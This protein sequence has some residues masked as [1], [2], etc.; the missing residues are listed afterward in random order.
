MT[1]NLISFRLDK[2]TQ[3]L[4]EK[5]LRDGESLSLCASRLLRESLGLPTDV[6]G[7]V[8]IVNLD[9]FISE[10]LDLF[11]QEIEAN[12]SKKRIRKKSN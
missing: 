4:L 9:S 6:N 11:R 7:A 8:D 12:Y 5:N 2:L 3:E 10:K 1:S